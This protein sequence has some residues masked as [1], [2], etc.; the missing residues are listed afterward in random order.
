MSQPGFGEGREVGVVAVAEN[1]LWWNDV[2]DLDQ[3]TRV[4]DSGVEW[5][6]WLSECEVLGG[7]VILAEW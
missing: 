6:V 1:F 7:H 5:I 2:I 4:A 3:E